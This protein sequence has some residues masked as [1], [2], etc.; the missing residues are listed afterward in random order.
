MSKHCRRRLPWYEDRPA[1]SDGGMLATKHQP[2]VVAA[3]MSENA[4]HLNRGHTPSTAPSV[5]ATVQ[6]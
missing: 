2:V 1:E 5:H 4:R 3:I 6:E